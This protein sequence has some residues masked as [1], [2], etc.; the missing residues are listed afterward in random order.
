MNDAMALGEDA[1]RRLPKPDF[2][3]LP[4]K[5]SSK[6][7][8]HTKPSH[9]PQ[10][11]AADLPEVTFRAIAEQHAADHNL[12]FV[13]T[14]KSH[15]GTGKPLFKVSKSVDGRGGITV[16]V[17][18]DAVYAMVQDGVFRAILLDD[19]VKMAGGG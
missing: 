8:R 6:K 10:P 7:D 5:S 16:Y 4:V 9:R 14:G 15:P 11:P 1:P 18:E 3:P 2:K 13:P 19:M 12:V 17:G